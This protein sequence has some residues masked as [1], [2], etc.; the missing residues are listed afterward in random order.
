LLAEGKGDLKMQLLRSRAEKGEKRMTTVLIVQEQ[1]AARHDDRVEYEGKYN[2]VERL[3]SSL[4]L[5]ASIHGEWE[6]MG[7]DFAR[8]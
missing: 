4:S 2:E 1:L 6:W 8:V 5:I 7:Q 3:Y